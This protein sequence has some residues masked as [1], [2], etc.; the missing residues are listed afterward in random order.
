MGINISQNKYHNVRT[1]Y[2]GR[3]FA[4]KLEASHARDLDLMRR[5]QDPTQKVVAVNYQY[6][7]PVKVNGVL[8]CHYVADFYVMFEDGHKEIHET[9]G[10]RT[11]VYLIK[12]RLVE[13]IYGEKILEF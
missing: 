1:E 3:W 10:V 4:S 7:I 8:I 13:A 5:A 6:R 11:A 2:N 9:K 12:K